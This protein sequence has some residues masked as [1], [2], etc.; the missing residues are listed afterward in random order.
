[1]VPGKRS[2]LFKAIIG[3][4]R[5]LLFWFLDAS[6]Y[7]PLRARYMLTNFTFFTFCLLSYQKRENVRKNLQLILDRKPQFTEIMRVFLDYGQYWAELPRL[8]E[9][10]KSMQVVHE[11]DFPPSKSFLGVTFHIGNFELFGPE[12][13][14]TLGCN[15][16]VIAEHLYPQALTEYF[17]KM[18]M[19]HHIRTILH[20]DFRTIL[21]M[22]KSGESPLRRH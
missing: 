6:G 10:W 1:M 4:L 19:R 2:L 18:R 14:H 7:L 22:L 21:K 20:D 5:Y 3:F 16:N 11:G 8:H 15:F 9:F 13:Y 17:M 12:I